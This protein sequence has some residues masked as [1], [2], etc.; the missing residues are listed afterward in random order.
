MDLIEYP[1]DIKIPAK[2]HCQNLLCLSFQAANLPRAINPLD[3]WR[4]E[5]KANFPLICKIAYKFLILQGTSVPS[6]R[7]F[8]TAGTIISKKRN[9]LSDETASMLIFLNKNL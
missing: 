7:V 8:S 4:S 1:I 2:E 5:G 6:E 3:W 9:C